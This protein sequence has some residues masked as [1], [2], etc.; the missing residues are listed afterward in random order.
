VTAVTRCDHRHLTNQGPDG[1]WLSRMFICG[2]E[3]DRAWD[4]FFKIDFNV[5]AA[6]LCGDLTVGKSRRSETGSHLPQKPE[7]SR[8]RVIQE[9]LQLTS[10]GEIPLQ[11]TQLAKTRCS[12]MTSLDHS[13]GVN[14]ARS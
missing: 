2:G 14:A 12:T 13:A 5:G 8:E 7:F 9:S 11:A 6:L 10:S 1:A 4:T 3:L